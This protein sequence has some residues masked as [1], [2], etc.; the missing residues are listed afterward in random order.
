VTLS[1]G[2]RLPGSPG[3]LRATLTDSGIPL[4]GSAV[5]L[6]LVTAP[7]GSQKTLRLTAAEPGVFT[8]E[9]PTDAPGVYRVLVRALGA[10]LRGTPFTREEL[11]TLAVWARGD[12]PPPLVID[13]GHGADGG[14]DTCRLLA[15][16]LEDDGVRN[17][18][19]RNEIDPD[20]VRRCVKRACG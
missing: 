16:L 18:L 19:G 9:V 2:S 8:A 3:R 1:Q 7:D 15:C 5:V 12:E 20:R 11:R 10:D 13:P 14:I 4:A 17:Y 6:A